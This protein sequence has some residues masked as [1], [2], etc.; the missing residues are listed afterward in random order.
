[1]GSTRL[2]AGY[3]DEWY[4]DMGGSADRDAVIAGAMGLPAELRDAGVLSWSAIGEVASALELPAD[5]VLVDVA[6]GRGGY[7]IEIAK[8]AGGRLVGVD[9]S[10]VALAVAAVTG[11]E[12]LP[13]RAEFR[14]GDLAGTGLPDQVAD[15]VMCVDAVQFAA[16]PLAAV[17]EF[18]RLLKPGGRVA[19]TCWEAVDPAD[20]RVPARIRA[21]DLRRDLTTAGFTE[22]RVAEMPQWR[23]AERE[24]W[25]SAMAADGSDPAVRAMQDEGR[26]S[27][28]TFDAMRRVFAT[29]RRAAE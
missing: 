2:D 11:A 26:R 27:L 20:G 13:G 21:V 7:G 3:F 18:R 28:E 4:A 1:M 10:A 23:V 6:C 15:A 9:F 14:V 16:P 19:L 12:R 5:G 24:L 25:E 22:I 8:R 17:V 29:A